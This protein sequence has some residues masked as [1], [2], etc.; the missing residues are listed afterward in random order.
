MPVAEE[1]E[2]S[3]STLPSPVVG[4]LEQEVWIAWMLLSGCVVPDELLAGGLSTEA[5]FG[6]SHLTVGS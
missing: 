3:H 5:G 1:Q 2:N 6:D 4:G